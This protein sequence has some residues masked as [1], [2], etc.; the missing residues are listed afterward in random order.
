MQTAGEL[1]I[2]IRQMRTVPQCGILDP[3]A[4]VSIKVINAAVSIQITLTVI[5][6]WHEEL[7]VPGRLRPFR[8]LS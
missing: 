2:L 4:A 8:R 5:Q 6:T 7:R 3:I 1:F